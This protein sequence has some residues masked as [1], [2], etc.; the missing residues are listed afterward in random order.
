MN[1][2]LL[3]QN[4]GKETS[5][6]LEPTNFRRLMNLDIAASTAMQDD[7]NGM[8]D[9]LRAVR[10]GDVENPMYEA[11]TQVPEYYDLMD[12]R[13]PADDYVSDKLMV[14]I[15]ELF[16]IRGELEKNMNRRELA[17]FDKVFAK[18]LQKE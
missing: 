11:L 10:H 13:K 6:H 15:N 7:R 12:V 5:Y 9:Q 3:E 8:A 17:S 4:R 16:S 14:L 18:Y 2:R 1:Y